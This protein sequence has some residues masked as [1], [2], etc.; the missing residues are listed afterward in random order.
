MIG[1]SRPSDR[2]NVR[3]IQISLESR[4]SGIGQTLLWIADALRSAARLV[5]RVYL[6]LHVA[7]EF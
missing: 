7:K 1:S 2:L 5:G 4:Q 3:F 6:L